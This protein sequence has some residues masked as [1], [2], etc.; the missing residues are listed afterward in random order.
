MEKEEG[1][2]CDINECQCIE[3]SPC[4]KGVHSVFS[5]LLHRNDK[6][7]GVILDNHISTNGQALDSSELLIVYDLNIFDP[8]AKHDLAENCVKDG[9]EVKDEMAVHSKICSV[10]SN[11]LTHPLSQVYLQFKWACILKYF[12]FTF[13]IALSIN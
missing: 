4:E 13:K 2:Q 7:A 9:V 8:D 6:A 3:Q 10:K 5:T 12:T 11:L 1:K